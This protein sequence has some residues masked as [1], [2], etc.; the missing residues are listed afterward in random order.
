MLRYLV[1]PLFAFPLLSQAQAPYFNRLYDENDMWQGFAAAAEIDDVSNYLIAGR[2]IGFSISV[3]YIWICTISS[4]GDTIANAR[5]AS[6]DSSGYYIGIQSLVPISMG[7]YLAGSSVKYV[8][9]IPFSD[10]Y[11]M[12]LDHTG[13]RIWEKSFGGDKFDAFDSMVMDKEKNLVMAG[14]SYNFSDTLEGDIYVV[15]T[16]TTGEVIWQK[17][18]GVNNFQERC[19][20]IDTTADGGYV[21]TGARALTHNPAFL[22]SKSTAWETSSG[23]EF[24]RKR[25]PH[26][27]TLQN[28]D[29]LLTT[30]APVNGSIDQA[31]IV[32]ISPAGNILWL[33]HFPGKEWHA[34]FSYPAETSNGALVMAGGEMEFDSTNGNYWVLGTL[35]KTDAQGNLIWKRQYY[36][37]HDLDNYFFGMIPTSDLGF[38][39]YGFAYRDS[40]NR[41]DAWV[42]KVDSLGCLEPGCEGSV[43]APE[44]EA[45]AVALNIYPNPT[46]DRF[47]VESPGEPMLGLRLFDLNGRVLDDVQFFRQYPVR[48][49]RLSLAG[50]PPGVYV[51][52]VRTDKGWVGRKVV[53]Q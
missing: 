52:S 40:N 48:E 3:H 25:I 8:N 41:Q 47:T 5:I 22:S 20:G 26:I 13:N 51:L 36:T 18:W 43:A 24:Q 30:G 33:K 16:D 12:R 17:S 6:G 14:T 1:L 34:W 4:E 50:Q 37:R 31:K 49:Y 23:K 46:T 32:R 38:L 35:T 53:K 19:W 10:G 9:Q 11:L 27:K 39:M 15:K 42:V 7:Y 29:F 2:N 28:G 44:A 21:I 45:T